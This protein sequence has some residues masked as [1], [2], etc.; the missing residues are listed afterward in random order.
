MRHL[1]KRPSPAM[2]VALIA[3]FIALG[4]TTYAATGG[5]F[6]LGKPNSATSQTALSAP[7]ANK[8]LQVTNTGT[9]SGA[10]GI[11]ITVA[12]NHAP[13]TV[14]ANAG[15]ATNLN[16]DKVD[17]KEAADLVGARAWAKVNPRYCSG[18]PVVYCS[19]WGTP[20][21]AYIV[22][23]G[24]GRYCVGVSGIN[25]GNT[26][27]LVNTRKPNSSE[28]VDYWQ[29]EAY[30]IPADN[31]ENACVSSEFEFAT[32]LIAA[33]GP[34]VSRDVDFNFVIP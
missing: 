4:G 14:P 28:N 34:R 11:G 9:S 20:N 13:L 16:A 15:K 32:Y 33:A 2:G 17:G 7:I 24:V 27:A 21:I 6:I 10:A 18:S 30:W 25:A 3:L 8:T 26:I 22:K 19:V 23:V 1:L 12:A 31:G 5:N 29:F